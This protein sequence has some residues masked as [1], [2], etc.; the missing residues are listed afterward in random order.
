MIR[1]GLA[2]N[3]ELPDWVVEILEQS[4]IAVVALLVAYFA[5]REIAKTHKNHLESK[6]SEIK[7]LVDEKNALQE[8]VLRNR[9]ST[10]EDGAET[11]S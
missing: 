9:L 10:T 4:P 8:L 11:D 1:L 6:D 5:Y 3:I 7:R 2:V